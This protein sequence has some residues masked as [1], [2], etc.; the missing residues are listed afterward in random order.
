MSRKKQR[1]AYARALGRIVD[2]INA[3]TPEVQH[4]MLWQWLFVK[5]GMAIVCVAPIMAALLSWLGE[6]LLRPSITALPYF[7]YLAFVGLCALAFFLYWLKGRLK[8][9]YGAMEMAF[10]LAVISQAVRQVQ[11]HGVT[12]WTVAAAAVYVLVRGLEN[13]VAGYRNPPPFVAV[14]NAKSSA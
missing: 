13:L 8:Y 2:N 3:Q 1:E 11:D 4:R 7:E 12:A 14:S 6:L 10:A 9:L 5:I